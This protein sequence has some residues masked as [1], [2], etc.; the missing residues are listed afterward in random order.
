MYNM[1]IYN[2]KI[3]ITIVKYILNKIWIQSVKVKFTRSFNYSSIILQLFFNYSSIILQ[4][5]F[6]FSDFE[7]RLSYTLR[8]SNKSVYHFLSGSECIPINYLFCFLIILKVQVAQL[9]RDLLASSFVLA[10]FV[11]INLKVTQSCSQQLFIKRKIFAKRE[12]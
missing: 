2:L 1:Q 9:L 10:V 6:N 7:P 4:L 3:V 12:S 8:S 11:P 5:F